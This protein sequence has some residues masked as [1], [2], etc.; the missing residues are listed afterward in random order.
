[1]SLIGFPLCGGL[2]FPPWH[3]ARDQITS[4]PKL[5]LKMPYEESSILPYLLAN[6]NRMSY[7]YIEMAIMIKVPYILNGILN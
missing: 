4:S 7:L 2:Q 3:F 1:M 6:M 5:A